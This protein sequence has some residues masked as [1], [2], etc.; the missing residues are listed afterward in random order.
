LEEI[1]LANLLTSDHI[2]LAYEVAVRV[3]DRS[4]TQRQG[5]ECLTR[6]GVGTTYAN[7]LI[8]VYRIMRRGRCYHRAINVPT[9]VLYLQGIFRDAGEEALGQALTAA[10]LHIQY[11][12]QL[13]GVTLHR[14]REAVEHSELL[15]DHAQGAIAQYR[16]VL[17]TQVQ[18]ALNDT[19][20]ARQARLA[21]KKKA[22]P[23]KFTTTSTYFLRDPDVVAEAL[24]RADGSCEVCQK[25]A[26]FKRK[27]DGTPYLEVHHIVR[28][29]DG[30]MDDLDNV[31]VVCPNCHRQA[32][33]G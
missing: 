1:V 22:A 3:H 20:A 17:D 10:R 23:V 8:N 2:Q 31:S 25:P 6:E 18:V 26:P 5:V 24:H 33:F 14:I 16:R 7:D 15:I 21:K 13:R 29:S 28:L 32:H 30:G 27:S 11:Y 12:E 4:L 9:T 19:A